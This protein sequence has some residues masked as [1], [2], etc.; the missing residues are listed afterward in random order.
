MAYIKI[1]EKFAF[2]SIVCC[3]YYRLPQ[4]SICFIILPFTD[5]FKNAGGMARLLHEEVKRTRFFLAVSISAESRFPA[6]AS[7]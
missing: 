4:L 6:A 2:N 3:F 5:S 1:Y 7:S